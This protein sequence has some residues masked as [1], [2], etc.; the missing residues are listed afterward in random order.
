VWALVGIMLCLWPAS[1]AASAG[2]DAS[3]AHASK[4]S[5]RSLGWTHDL[6]SGPNRILVVGVTIEDNQDRDPGA[7]V[8][9]NGTPMLPV[10]GGLAIADDGHG[11]LRTHL[12]YLLER[13][14]PAAYQ[15]PGSPR[16]CMDRRQVDSLAR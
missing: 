5:G 4:S 7:V 15:S 16:P 6:G 1:A 12:F 3:R 8:T 11:F 10:P 13:A 9:F 14:P 2:F